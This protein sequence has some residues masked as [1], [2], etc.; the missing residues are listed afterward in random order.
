MFTGESIR[1]LG[2]MGGEDVPQNFDETTS[3]KVLGESKDQVEA[4]LQ[5]V[6]DA[7]QE[8]GY[9]AINQLVG[10]MISGDPAYVTSYKDAR[11]MIT[12][13][14]RDEIMEVVLRKFLNVF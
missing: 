4:I 1:L 11:S 2:L 5:M 13:V 6:Y 7:L 9:N 14:E 8:K 3:F 12:K 10:Y